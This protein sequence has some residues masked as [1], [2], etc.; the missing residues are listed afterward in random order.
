M[1]ED[2]FLIAF[3]NSD[4]PHLY[5]VIAVSVQQGSDFTKEQFSSRSSL[6]DVDVKYFNP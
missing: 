2:R 3:F 5:S 1:A 4:N 6:M